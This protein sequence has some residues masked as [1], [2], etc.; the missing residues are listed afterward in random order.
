MEAIGIVPSFGQVENKYV[1]ALLEIKRLR[2]DL[3]LVLEV[4]KDLRAECDEVIKA[5]KE[6]TYKNLRMQSEVWDLRGKVME[7]V[8]FN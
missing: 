6:L 8:S 1:D 4:N 3:E 5:N 7:K 2:K